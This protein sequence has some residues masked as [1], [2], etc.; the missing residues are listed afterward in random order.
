MC[1]KCEPLLFNFVG[2]SFLNFHFTVKAPKFA[3]KFIEFNY[4]LD[5][6]SCFITFKFN[7]YLDLWRNLSLAFNL[8]NLDMHYFLLITY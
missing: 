1:V 3:A 6:F 7:Y 5:R 8:F 4:H 2:Q